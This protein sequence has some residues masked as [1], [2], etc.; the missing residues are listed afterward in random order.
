M[1]NYILIV[2]G[3]HDG[4]RVPRSLVPSNYPELKLPVKP[5]WK[6]L[7]Y[8]SQEAPSLGDFPKEVTY[9]REWFQDDKKRQHDLFVHENVSD[10]IGTLIDGYS[11]RKVTKGDPR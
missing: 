1:D 9:H 2:G 5:A 3:P 8:E 11:P 7:K 6:P 10:L 4:E